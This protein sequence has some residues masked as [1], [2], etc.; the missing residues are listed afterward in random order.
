MCTSR[1]RYVGMRRAVSFLNTSRDNLLTYLAYLL[2]RSIRYQRLIES[3]DFQLKRDH[4]DHV[5]SVMR[6]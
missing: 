3:A 4:S 1:C 6:P 2:L 5:R